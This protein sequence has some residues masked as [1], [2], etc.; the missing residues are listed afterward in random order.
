MTQSSGDRL[1]ICERIMLRRI[2]GPVSETDLGWRL[3]HNK[4]IYEL[5]DVP[6]SKI[7]SVWK[8]TMGGLIVWMDNI[9]IP[10]KDTEW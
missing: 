6:D 7:Y 4:G 3:S 8:I 1:V 9:R 5:L 2:F 10:K